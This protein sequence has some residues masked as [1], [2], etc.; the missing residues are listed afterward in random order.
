MHRS[1]RPVKPAQSKLLQYHWDNGQY[2][3]HRKRVS[4]ARSEVDTRPPAT[5]MHLHLKLKKLQME[6]ER[7]AVIE[8]DNRILLAKMSDTMRTQGRVDHR[9]DNKYSKS[10]N[11]DRRSHE[12]L[13][14]TRENQDILERITSAKSNYDHEVME[15]DWRLNRKYMSQIS[16]YS[17]YWWR[18]GS[19]Y[20]Q[21]S[22]KSTRFAD[23]QKTKSRTT[24]DSSTAKG[25][26]SAVPRSA[27]SHST[28]DGK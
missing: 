18:S 9:N 25:T 16:M 1:Y 27:Q 24:C 23:R 15:Q 26:N 11:Q 28:Q 6:E 13:R 21:R 7:M 20:S 17:D 10:L 12:A 5:Y 19:A 14:V 4:T 22:G 3:Q 8:R 2:E